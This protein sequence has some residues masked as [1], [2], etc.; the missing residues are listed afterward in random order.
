LAPDFREVG[1]E[2]VRVVVQAPDP[3]SAA[4]VAS[5]FR[6]R[7]DFDVVP[8]EYRSDADVAVVVVGAFTPGVVAALRRAAA[9]LGTPVVLVVDGI[10]R[11][12]LLT[13]VECRV[14]AVVP[15]AAAT[16]ERLQRAVEVAFTGGGVLPVNLV[17]ELIR[18]VEEMQR[19]VGSSNCLTDREI[20]VVRLLA[21]GLDT[22]GIARE[23]SLSERTV[24]NVISGMTTRLNLRNRS[25]AVAYA[26]RAGVI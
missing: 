4:G 3:I 18:H 24:K 11:G 10:S 2:R 21:D 6:A 12:E 19:E 16:S 13:A 15:R 25:H 23:L 22:L 8:V 17:G 26:M 14:V 5:C 1:V 20:D 9:E 7:V